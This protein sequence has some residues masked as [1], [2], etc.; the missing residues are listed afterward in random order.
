M[1]SVL[2]FSIGSLFV[3]NIY[4][5]K[6]PSEIDDWSNF[7]ASLSIKGGKD[8]LCKRTNLFLDLALFIGLAKCSFYPSILLLVGVKELKLLLAER[9]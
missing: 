8:S 6:V 3:V 1:S 2:T 9:S 5:A 4:S 7:G